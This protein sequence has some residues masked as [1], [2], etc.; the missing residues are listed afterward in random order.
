MN[1]RKNLSET[2]NQIT[3]PANFKIGS[4]VE[5]YYRFLHFLFE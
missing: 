2:T 5:V 3:E 1:I 4:Q